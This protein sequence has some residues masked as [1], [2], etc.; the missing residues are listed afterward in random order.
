MRDWRLAERARYV[1]FALLTIA[2][3]LAVHLGGAALGATARDVLGDALWG[4]MIAWWVGALAP[5]T[6]LALRISVAYL[7]CV[8]VEISQLMHSPALD[9]FR[10]TRIGHLILGS[11]FDPRDLVA[12]AIGVGI[13]GLLLGTRTGRAR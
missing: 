11:G 6:R 3:G 1:A 7:I 9:A 4:A 8:A 10:A 5:Q 12:Y 2:I 13:V